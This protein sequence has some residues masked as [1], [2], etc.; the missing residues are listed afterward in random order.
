MIFLLPDLIAPRAPPQDRIGILRQDPEENAVLPDFI[1][2]MSV[3]GRYRLYI[4]YGQRKFY[5]APVPSG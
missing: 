2:G 1:L 4:S 3:L 5:L